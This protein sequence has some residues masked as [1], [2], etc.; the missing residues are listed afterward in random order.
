[1]KN[2]LLIAGI[3]MLFFYAVPSFA[4]ET[5]VGGYGELHYN[6]PEGSASGVLDFHR[7]VLYLGHSFNSWITFQSELEL[8]H[9]F[10]SPG[11]S[12]GELSLEQAFLE[13]QPWERYGFKAGIIPVPVGII[14]QYHEPPTFNG[15]E[16]P[17][18]EKYILP[19]TWSEPGIGIYGRP[20]DGVSFQLYTLTSLNAA[21]FSRDEGIREGR[22]EGYR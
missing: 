1:M 3:I 11:E 10:I 21:G 16:R 12:S 5:T 7:F 17:S 22:Q 15:V 14:N 6:D 8:E 9:T 19:S 2:L 18:Y 20:V 13:F 4:Q